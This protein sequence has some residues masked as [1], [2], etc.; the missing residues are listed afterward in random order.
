MVIDEIFNLQFWFVDER[1]L[2]FFMRA[3][4]R[5]FFFANGEGAITRQ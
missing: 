1:Y 5:L 2:G 4:G 3:K